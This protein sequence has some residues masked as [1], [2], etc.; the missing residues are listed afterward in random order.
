MATLGIVYRNLIS[1]RFSL[2]KK[3]LLCTLYIFPT[4]KW[5]RSCRQSQGRNIPNWSLRNTRTVGNDINLRS[6]KANYP[7]KNLTGGGGERG[8][9]FLQSSYSLAYPRLSKA[10]FLWSQLPSQVQVGGGTHTAPPPSPW[11][12]KTHIGIV[13]HWDY[14]PQMVSGYANLYRKNHEYTEKR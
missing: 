2:G 5:Q 7:Y 11:H 13:F 4:Y 10:W 3:H 12:A 1:A 9:A 14:C 8:P 6:K